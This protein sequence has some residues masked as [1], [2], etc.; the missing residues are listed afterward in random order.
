MKAGFAGDD[1]P[2]GITRNIF[3]ANL[4]AVFPSLHPD[5]S[6]YP[7]ERSI[8]KDWDNLS[9]LWTQALE[10]I[11]CKASLNHP[12]FSIIGNALHQHT[13]R[14][15]TLNWVDLVVHV[16]RCH[17]LDMSNTPPQ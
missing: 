3:C 7:I 1:I 12:C 9:K 15:A 17:E 11:S 8:V 13:K 14:V 10:R 4:V 6:S 16:D 2:K 5:F